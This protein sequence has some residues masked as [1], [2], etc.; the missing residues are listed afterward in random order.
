MEQVVRWIGIDR[1]FAGNGEPSSEW[2]TASRLRPTGVVV[3]AALDVPTTRRYFPE[4][5]AHVP[6]TRRR[7]QD[8]SHGWRRV[9]HGMAWLLGR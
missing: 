1:P 3:F 9:L 8:V 5:R 2:S 7:K 6:T 4:E